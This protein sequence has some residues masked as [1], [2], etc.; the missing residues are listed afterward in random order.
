MPRQLRLDCVTRENARLCLQG[1]P[2]VVLVLM[3]STATFQTHPSTRTTTYLPLLTQP[4]PAELQRTTG[5]TCLRALMKPT[6]NQ[7]S[8]RAK[9][10]GTLHS[11]TNSVSV[12]KLP[13][14]RFHLS[15]N[16]CRPPPISMNHPCWAFL[17]VLCLPLQQRTR[18]SSRSFSSLQY[19]ILWGGRRRPTRPR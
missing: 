9:S 3:A 1:R 17:V 14:Y 16:L 4:L 12:C 7:S 19:F 10:I 18:N 5:T 6:S 11:A 15:S 2:L 8:H 13:E